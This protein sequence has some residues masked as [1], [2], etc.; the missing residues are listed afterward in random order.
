MFHSWKNSTAATWKI[1]KRCHRRGGNT[2]EH[3]GKAASPLKR[4]PVGIMST[5]RAG[6]TV[7]PGPGRDVGYLKA[8]LN[9]LQGY[10]P[11]DLAY[12]YKTIQG[13]Y[14]TLS[15]GEFDLQEE[16][17]DTG[18]SVSGDVRY[19]LGYSRD[20]KHTDGTQIHISLVANP[21]H[22]ESVDPVVQGKTRGIQL[23]RGD[24]NRKKVIPV[25]IHGDAAFS[26][27]GVVSETLNLSKLRGYETGGTIHIIVNNQIG[28]TTS[29]RDLRS[30]FFPTDIAKSMPVPIFHVNG[31]RPEYV[32]RAIE[33]AYRFRQKFG[34][35][36]IV[37]IFCY[38]K[39]GH[40]EADGP[41]FTHPIMYDMI[42]ASPGVTA[43]CGI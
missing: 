12:V 28:F 15:P 27:Q 7:S 39:Y 29:S 17:L 4:H 8:K 26:G 10:L 14:E 38:R 13:V 3:W 1:L 18:F 32:I 31:E 22:L 40:N 30:T 37:D 16:D 25:L 23:R 43:V 6:W 35:D 11:K 21:S 5:S 34:Y 9:P 20:H 36:A 42:K 2:F 33:L 41:S 19:H 24:H